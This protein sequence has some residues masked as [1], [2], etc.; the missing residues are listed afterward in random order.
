MVASEQL[1]QR[2]IADTP[3]V[4]FEEAIKAHW[5]PSTNTVF[6]DPAQNNYIWSVLHE[7]GHREAE[8]TI[9]TFDIELLMMESEAWQHA[10]TIAKKY[11]HHIDQDHI[12]DC[13]D[14]YRNWLYKRSTCP[15]CTQTGLQENKK[16]YRCLNC[17]S[18]WQVT[19]SRFCRPY[20]KTKTPQDK[21]Q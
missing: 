7:L 8:H 9:Y 1:L 2:I 12:E 21:R 3:D 15:T 16:T 19:A 6:Y 17:N 5:E 13:L 14:S 10:K 20:R 4:N 18:I 11:S